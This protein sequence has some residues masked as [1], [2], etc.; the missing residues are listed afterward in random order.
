MPLLVNRFVFSMVPAQ[1]PFFLRPLLKPIFSAIDAR[2]IAGPLNA[3]LKLVC[4][5]YVD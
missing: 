2:M 5:L 3:S 4:R 1:S